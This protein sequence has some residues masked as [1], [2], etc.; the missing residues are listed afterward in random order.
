MEDETASTG[1]IH[2]R[3]IID[4]KQPCRLSLC[5]G[6]IPMRLVKIENRSFTCDKVIKTRQGRGQL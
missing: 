5:M 3:P 2:C 1:L 4:P 6:C